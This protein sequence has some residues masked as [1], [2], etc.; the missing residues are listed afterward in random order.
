MQTAKFH[1]FFPFAHGKIRQ[2]GPIFDRS[3]W[4]R[5][6]R[7]TRIPPYSVSVAVAG[8]GVSF[9][10]TILKVLAGHPEGRASL[11]DLK[12]YVPVLTSSGADWSQRMKRLAARA[13]DLDIF[14]S[15]YV[16]REPTGWQIT[17]KGREFLVLIEAPSAEPA[18]TPV[19]L[20]LPADLPDL[21]PNVVPLIGHKVHRRRRRAA[22]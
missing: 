1:L 9:Q 2:S 16:L 19:A 5:I 12:H 13:P 4:T 21:P 20:P 7:D 15:G 3:R 11:A 10:I 6:Y 18:L 22:A 8:R 14:S 17:A